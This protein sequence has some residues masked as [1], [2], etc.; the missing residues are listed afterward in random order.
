[1]APAAGGGQSERGMKAEISTRMASTITD[2]VVDMQI[3]FTISLFQA[4]A[5][6]EP[7]RK[8]W[9]EKLAE[10]QKEE[11]DKKAKEA[12]EKKA[13]ASEVT[14]TEATSTSTPD[15]SNNNNVEAE[16]KEEEE[17]VHGTKKMKSDFDMMMSSLDA[18]M[19]AGRSKLA[20]L[21][22]RIRRAKGAIKEA[23][24]ALANDKKSS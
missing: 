9:R 15:D 24:D 23:D 22:E 7:E 8:S 18:E 2:E 13:A 5:D 17:D 3:L 16:K 20:K 10:K 14:N 11:A 12:A 1:M 21:R 19:E 6:P 4:A